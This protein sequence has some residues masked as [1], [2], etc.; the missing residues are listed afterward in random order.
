M[1]LSWLNYNTAD[2]QIAD[3]VLLSPAIAASCLMKAFC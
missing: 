1:I 2:F 3:S